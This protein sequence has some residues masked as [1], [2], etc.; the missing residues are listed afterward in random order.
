MDEFIKWAKKHDL[1]YEPDSR[2][3]QEY[4]AFRNLVRASR[5]W[6]NLVDGLI[7]ART[8]Q[9]RGRWETLF[10]IGF[11][12]PPVTISTLADRMSLRWPT[13]VRVLDGLERDGLI[14]RVENPADK[15]SRFISLSPAGREVIRQIKPML[16]AERARVLAGFSEEEIKLLT[17][18][19]D[20]MLK[21]T[22][23]WQEAAAE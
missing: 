17:A 12:K 13:L 23:T 5:S 19:L 2:L 20:R 21:S 15:R 14:T 6:T 11:N 8:G 1:V 4:H 16:D 18:L 22:L 3:D 10:A 9:T 7:R